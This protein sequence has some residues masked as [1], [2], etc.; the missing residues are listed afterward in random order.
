MGLH[1]SDSY[2]KFAQGNLKELGF[3]LGLGLPLRNQRTAL[4]LAMEFGKILTPEPSMIQNITG[5]LNLIC[6]L[7]KP[8]LLNGD[9][10]SIT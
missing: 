6:P 10:I 9:L 1:Y 2:I 7:M 5:E 8:G 3:S 4:N